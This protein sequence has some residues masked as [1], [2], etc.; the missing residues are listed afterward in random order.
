MGETYT[1]RVLV[2]VVGRDFVFEY[3][4]GETYTTRVLGEGEGLT[5]KLRFVYK[6]T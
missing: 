2:E 6:I 4:M 5:R 3:V 1:S